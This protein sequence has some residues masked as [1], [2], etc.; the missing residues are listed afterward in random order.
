MMHLSRGLAYTAGDNF[1]A[2]SL[3]YAGES[4]SMVLI[5]P[6]AGSFDAVE[7]ALDSVMFETVVAALDDEPVALSLPKFTF[8][9]ETQLKKTLEEMGMVDAFG[10]GADFSLMDGRP[11]LFIDEVYHKAFIQVD[12]EGTEAA[13][14]TAVVVNL[15]S[16]APSGITLTI[17]RP[18]IFAIRDKTGTVL[19]MGRVLNPSS[20]PTK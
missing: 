11:D 12:E 16:A 5:V 7:N 3:P 9:D 19:F 1:E 20:N 13:A 15:K 4:I 2:I 17:D 14:A 10:A 6:D 18:F 8:E